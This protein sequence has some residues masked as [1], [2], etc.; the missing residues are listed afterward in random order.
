MLCGKHK[1]TVTVTLNRDGNS[2]KETLI[3]SGRYMP[4]SSPVD[5]NTRYPVLKI[6]DKNI[7]YV[8]MGA[9][10]QTEV[11]SMFTL[12]K[13]TKAIIFDI[14]NY[15]KGTAWSIAPRLTATP[16]KAV[17]FHYPLVSY[18]N[19]SGGEDEITGESFFTVLPDTSKPVYKGKIIILCN[20]TTQSQAEYSIMMFQG[21]AN[22]TVIGSQTAGADGNVTNIILPGN[23]RTS[24]SGLEI[25]YPDGGQTQRSG[26]R[27]DIQSAPTV[28]GLRAGKDEVMERAMQYIETG[29]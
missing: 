1:T 12:F 23:Y 15:P 20:A 17:K 19:I 25:L 24:F 7:G 22:A 4:A 11:D 27:I 5:F 8:N 16:K 26:I 10:R 13:E 28:A 2:I 29:K 21:A 14:R 18:K 6:M 9:L 3:R